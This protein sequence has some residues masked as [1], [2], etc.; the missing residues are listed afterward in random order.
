MPRCTEHRLRDRGFLTAWQPCGVTREEVG[1][2]GLQSPLSAPSG[3]SSLDS[4]ITVVRP[5]PSR[6]YRAEDVRTL[7]IKPAIRFVD[8]ILKR[9]PSACTSFKRTT[10]ANY[11]LA[12]MAHRGGGPSASIP[13]DQILRRGAVTSPSLVPP[14]R[15]LIAPVPVRRAPSTTVARTS[16]GRCTRPGRATAPRDRW[17]PRRDGGGDRDG[18]HGVR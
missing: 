16:R 7:A 8:E 5:I 1:C 3:A 4:A 15:A 6:A 2:G 12:F 14:A 9:R 18:P 11:S 17:R 10:A 13:Y